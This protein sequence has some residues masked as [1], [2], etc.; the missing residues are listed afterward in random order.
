MTIGS[1]S[2]TGSDDGSIDR[3]EEMLR[4]L[5]ESLRA[6]ALQ[7]NDGDMLAETLMLDV[8][9]EEVFY[10]SLE[11]MNESDLKTHS[12]DSIIRMEEEAQS[13]VFPDFVNEVEE[14]D[15]DGQEFDDSFQFTVDDTSHSHANS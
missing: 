4:R 7:N 15:E 2:S 6:E 5:A 1:D 9:P 10:T 13:D 3:E 8:P 11:A 12:T 14:A